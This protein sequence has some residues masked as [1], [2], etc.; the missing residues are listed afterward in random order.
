MYTS[1]LL[2]PEPPD[3]HF[4]IGSFPFLPP[5]RRNRISVYALVLM[6]DRFRL[7]I[8]RLN[9]SLREDLP[10]LHTLFNQSVSD[11]NYHNNQEE[12]LQYL[13]LAAP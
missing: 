6:S 5:R 9:L 1:F 12:F 7:Y 4:L 11:G 13:P 3:G 2:F 10:T 8:L